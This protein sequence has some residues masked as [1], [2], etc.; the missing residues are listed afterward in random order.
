MKPFIKDNPNIK[1]SIDCHSTK[2]T[3]RLLKNEEIDIGLICETELPKNIT[4][5]H[6][7]SIHDIFVANSDYIDNFPYRETEADLE[8]GEETADTQPETTSYPVFSG[9]I[10]GNLIPLMNVRP[11]VS[12]SEVLTEDH[13]RDIFRHS[14]LMMLEEANVTRTHVDN[15]LNEHSFHCNQL[16]EINNMDL[17]LD[18]AA[19]GMGIASVVREFSE[20]YLK[21]GRIVEIP[22]PT[23]IPK[24]SVGF[25]Y[26]QNRHQSKALCTFLDYCKIS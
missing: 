4:Y 10:M 17:L 23:P 14:T 9:S 12:D 7:R 8:A 11:S 2:N 26:L 21:D 6:V 25:A 13:I 24:R 19:I 3:I 18:F 15:Y 22:L 5:S 16:L 20:S 1:V